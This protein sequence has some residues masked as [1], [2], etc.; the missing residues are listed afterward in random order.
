MR[1]KYEFFVEYFRSK[2][3]FDCSTMIL[4]FLRLQKVKSIWRGNLAAEAAEFLQ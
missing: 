2:R 1:R 3:N 4:L